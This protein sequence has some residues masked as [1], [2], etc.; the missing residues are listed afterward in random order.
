MQSPWSRT[1]VGLV[2]GLVAYL[3]GA[4]LYRELFLVVIG[5]PP[6]IILSP[7]LYNLRPVFELVAP[8]AAGVIAGL[9]APRFPMLLAALSVTLDLPLA[10]LFSMVK[11]GVYLFVPDIDGQVLAHALVA[12]LAGGAAMH[13]KSRLTT[14]SS[15]L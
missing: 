4:A 6:Q 15:G 2:S 14:R 11:P 7:L 3:A 9:C 12:A 5:G 1:F 8:V 10:A 13:L